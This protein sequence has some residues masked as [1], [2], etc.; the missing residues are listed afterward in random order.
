VNAAGENRDKPHPSLIRTIAGQRAQGKVHIGATKSPQADVEL[1]RLDR[2]AGVAQQG[3]LSGRDAA[4]NVNAGVGAARCGHDE[5]IDSDRNRVTH[6]FAGT[7]GRHGRTGCALSCRETFVAIVATGSA[8][9]PVTRATSAIG[10]RRYPADGR[11][12]QG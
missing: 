7:L 9:S 11:S 5:V 8:T 4:S 3:V 6:E 10:N 2:D 12:G 1:K